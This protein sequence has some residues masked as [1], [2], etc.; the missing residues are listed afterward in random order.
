M[1]KQNLYILVVNQNYRD[2][3]NSIKL[4]D[5]CYTFVTLQINLKV[6]ENAINLIFAV[7]EEQ[8]HLYNRLVNHIEGS[9]AGVLSNDSSNV[10]E[11]VK[12]QY[13]VSTKSIFC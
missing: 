3:T 6:K 10:V 4:V 9:F 8:I 7:T 1:P 13:D 5:K 12:D 2:F 11:L